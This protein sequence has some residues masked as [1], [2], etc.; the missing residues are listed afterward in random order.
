MKPARFIL[1]FILLFIALFARAQKADTSQFLH[2]NID[3][4]LPSNNVYSVIQDHAG[5]IWFCTDEGLVKYNG[6]ELRTF[7]ARDSLPSSDIWAIYPDTLGRNWIFSTSERF[8]YIKDDKFN[9]VKVPDGVKILR[10]NNIVQLGNS[11]VFSYFNIKP[12][13]GIVDQFGIEKEI[14]L[15]D[16]DSTVIGSITSTGRIYLRTYYSLKSLYLKDSRFVTVLN[17]KL[18]P[19]FTPR[20]ESGNKLL[21]FSYE[22]RYFMVY[23]MN[24][25]KLS[26][27]YFKDLGGSVNETTYTCISNGDSGIL[28]SNKAVYPYRRNLN[29]QSRQ[30]LTE[31]LPKRSQ[32]SCLFT[33]RTGITWLTTNSDGA[34]MQLNKVLLFNISGKLNWLKNCTYLGA[35]DNGYSL[36]YNK[37]NSEFQVLSAK[38]RLVYKEHLPDQPK[39]TRYNDSIV[40]VLLPSYQYFFN[41]YNF[42]K[43]PFYNN[44]KNITAQ[45]LQIQRSV[46]FNNKNQI[47]GDLSANLIARYNDTITYICGTGIIKMTETAQSYKKHWLNNTKYQYCIYDSTSKKFLFANKEELAVLDPITDSIKVLNYKYLKLL[48]ANT[49]NQLKSDQYR[50]IYILTDNNLLVYNSSVNNL[51]PIQV[52]TDLSDA[53]ME[54]YGSYAFLAGR[55]GICYFQIKGVNVFGPV[56]YIPNVQGHFYKKLYNFSITPTANVII[57]TDKGVD[58]FN[59]KRIFEAKKIDINRYMSIVVSPGQKILKEADTFNFDQNL[60]K[61]NLDLIN[62]YGAGNRRYTYRVDGGDWQVSEIGDILTA[63]FQIGNYHRVDFIVS[64]NLWKSRTYTFYI[65]RVPYWFQTS[66]WKTIFWIIS[67]VLFIAL[68]ITAILITRTLV[69]RANEKKRANTELQLRAVYAQINPHFI[70]NT[71]SAAMFYINSKR[72]DEAYLHVNK[73]SKLLRGYLKSA[74]ERYITLT[75][76][77]NM[78]RSYIELQQVRFEGRFDYTINIDNKIPADSLQIPS[79]LLQPLVENAIN[80]GLFHKQGKGLLTIKFLQGSNN[81]EVICIIEDNGVGRLKAKEINQANTAKR[82]SYGT[83]L[84][85]QLIDL[86]KQYEQM[87]ITVEYVDKESP[88][89][90]TIVKLIIRNLKYVA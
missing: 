35:A 42:K 21:S 72:I 43:T 70:F 33:D 5:Y 88:D 52:N 76:E 90:G 63:D 2:F 75:E 86:F 41:C 71:L 67:I 45:H 49:I 79:L 68:L 58:T 10:P 62:Y 8:G 59:L 18:N 31:I 60:Q 46:V 1:P 54:I 55:F 78:L 57:N 15:R 20:R 39:I 4:G 40:Y 56:K 19:T 77:V 28:I 29:F 26:N 83:K 25:R 65:Y 84:T 47:Y 23:D 69:A 80:H 37:V 51:Q 34:W 53:T 48:N 36:W 66:K 7:N 82:D 14:S 64:D 61:F 50:N 73:F 16:D 38:M 3:N 6:Y 9:L 44:K 12:K 17:Q 13:I 22:S 11:I 85:D 32:L 24:K 89:T 30:L 81:D 74:Q 87:N 27:V